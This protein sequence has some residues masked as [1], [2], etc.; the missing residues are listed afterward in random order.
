MKRLTL[1]TPVCWL[2]LLAA[3]TV[4]VAGDEAATTP[5]PTRE[6][7]P[8]PTAAATL[9]PTFH[10]P[11][12]AE[13]AGWLTH[14][15]GKLESLAFSPDGRILATGHNNG[16]VV[17]WEMAT[18]EERR[19]LSHP[20]HQGSGHDLVFNADGSLLAVAEAVAGQ[21][22]LW[23]VFSGEK[24]QTLEA[25]GA[26]GQPLS[27]VAFSPDGSLL[28]AARSSGQSMEPAGRAFVWRTA[29]WQQLHVLE[30]AAPPVA[31]SPDGRRLFTL[32]GVAFV[33]WMPDHELAPIVQWDLESGERKGEIAIDGFVISLALCPD[34]KMLAANTVRMGADGGAFTLLLDAA[35]NAILHTLPVPD[36]SQ[37]PDALNFSPDGAQLAVGYQ[38]RVVIWDTATGTALRD[39]KGPAGWLTRPTFTPD[40]MLLAADSSDGRILFWKAPE[41]N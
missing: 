1:I 10:L 18:G 26:M 8:E 23:D 9:P 34:G 7:A 15:H 14:N 11:N 25:E 12:D 41:S 19:L 4:E 16:D 33:A 24:L 22:T 35:N 39:L 28:V 21:V 40:Q 6:E 32:S 27:D 3:C 20:Q 37:A 2:L 17:L 36:G 38:N 31:F 5:A 13:D 30:D 29:D